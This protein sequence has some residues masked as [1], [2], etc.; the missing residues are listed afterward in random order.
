MKQQ[1]YYNAKDNF[2]LICDMANK[3]NLNEKVVEL[4][5]S[6]NLTT[7]DQIKQFF[8]PS[9]ADFNNPFLLSGME[10][11]CKRIKKA[12]ENKERILVFG[13]YDVDGVSASAIVIGTLKKFGVDAFY[14][15]P[16][17][18]VDG[19]GLTNAVIDKVKENFN[20][21]LIITVDCGISCHQEVEYAKSLG[22]EIIV[23]D[24][25]EIPETLPN[26]IVVNP[27]LTNQAYPFRELCGTG[28]ALKLAQA[29]LG[30][31][32]C[33][34]FLPIA[35]I[36]TIADIVS[37]TEENRAI[38]SLGLKLFEKHL[39]IGLKMLFKEN[40]IP[41]KN[42]SSTEIAFKIAPKI[43]SSGR[44]GDASDSLKLYL[45]TNLNNIKTQLNIINDYNTKRQK[46]CADVYDDCVLK[47]KNVNLSNERSIILYDK[48]WDHGILG[49]VCAR[50]V[51][52]YNRPVF[53][54]SEEDGL[55]KGSARSIPDVNVHEILSSMSDILETF[56]GHKMA[57]GLCLKKEHI[58][59]FCQNVNNF[60]LTK[61]SPNAFLPVCFYD[62]DIE[63]SQITDKF[64]QDIEKLEPFGLN[65]AKPLLK[66]STSKAKVSPLKNFSNHY[67]ISIGK[68]SLIYF[69]CLDKYFALKYAK[70][71][72][73]I[74]EIQNKQAGQIKGIVKNFDGGFSLDKSFSS[75][76]DAYV[77]EQLKYV[78]NKQKIDVILYSQEKLIELLAECENS[79]FGTIFVSSKSNSYRNF[80]DVYSSQNISELFVFN[81]S[82]D[83]GA[84]ALY[85]YPT[86]LNIFKNYKKIVFLEPI[87]DK[88]YIA[89]IQKY[90][91]GQIYIPEN[92]SFDKKLFGTLNLT[93]GAFVEFFVKLKQFNGQIVSNIS[94]LYNLL[95]K[96]IKINFNNFYIYYLILSEL[97]IIKLTS[98]PQQ[99]TL[100]INDKIKTD[101]YSSKIYK[102]ANYLKQ[103]SRWN[104]GS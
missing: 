49:I 15:L 80:V 33:H 56:G 93:R 67:N 90:T 63:E 23:T 89:E 13:D 87:L 17:R 5:F 41:L 54:F 45:E 86:N 82:S 61:V 35:A 29:L 11:A 72:N 31:E 77:F 58:N 44:M 76:L 36:A 46:A 94:H 48:N 10:E 73:I 78:G 9:F 88:S 51:E 47:L 27:K 92:K 26:T 12:I 69:N 65:N 101:L 22:I 30:I 64:L 98:G 14:Y 97:G 85:L 96:K 62:L 32:N 71:K 34:E 42:P 4:L 66:I 99:L 79:T 50:L 91:T 1:K 28:V 103:I 38:V 21:N 75:N 25:H 100:E 8:N 70:T 39:P 84:N 102:L 20:P 83:S 2:A 24:H 16:N 95:S 37:L 3:L 19:Y 60:I 7:E 55:L 81:N 43:N 59:L 40:K 74:F 6:R 18:F 53:L 68:L 104:N 57:A 52:T